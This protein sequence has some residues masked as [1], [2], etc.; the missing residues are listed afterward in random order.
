MSQEI[1]VLAQTL[2]DLHARFTPHKGQIAPIR[3]IFELYKLM[4]QLDCGR[5]YGKTEIDLYV[6]TRW[7]LTKPGEYYLIGPFAKQQAEIVWHN[8][9]LPNFPPPQYVK[10]AY[11]SDY[12]LVF[13][14]GS[15]IKVD[16]SDNHQAYRGVNPHGMV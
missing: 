2:K 11:D 13:T 1:Q 12:R 16:G 15:F 14:N 8:R 7:A 6:L 4:V 3:D 5:K 10:K 9:R